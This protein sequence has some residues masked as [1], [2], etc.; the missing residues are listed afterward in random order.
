MNHQTIDFIPLCQSIHLG[1]QWL[2]SMGY[3]AH[4]FNINIQYSMNL[5]RHALQASEIDRVTQ[6]RVSDDYYIHINRQISQWNIGISS[7]LANAIGIAPFKDVFL[8]KSIS[9]WCSI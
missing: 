1:K 8:V 2:T 4:L 6:A 3:A 9:T 7:M 5:P